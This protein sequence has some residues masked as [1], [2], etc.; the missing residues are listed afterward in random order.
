MVFV[1]SCCGSL[2][3]KSGITEAVLTVFTSK[4]FQDAG[5]FVLSL[6]AFLP[7]ICVS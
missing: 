3:E 4:Y 6:G 1:R 5:N 7:A 2:I